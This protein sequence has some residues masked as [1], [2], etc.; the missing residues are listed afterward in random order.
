MINTAKYE[1]Q[2]RI[3]GTYIGD[4]RQLA[5]NLKWVRR[6]TRVGVDEIDFT[7]ND[8]L[9]QK[10]CLERNVDINTMLKPLALDCRIVRNGVPVVGGFLATMP[11]YNP[12]GTSANLD[13]RFDG[14]LN[15]LA[16][17]YMYPVGTQTGR[18]GTLI[19]NWIQL[20][21]QRATDAGKGFN[22]ASG[23][24][25]TMESVIYTF[26]NYKAIKEAITD[27]C[28]NVTGAGP[29]DVFFHPDRTYDIIK[30]SEF[31]DTITDYTI[32]YPTEL[33]A[34]SATQISASEVD[35]FASSVIG[36]GS[37]EISSEADKNTAIT[38]FMT[39]SDAV[40]EFGYAET[41]LQDSSVS[42]QTT[43]DQNSAALLNT[44]SNPI[45]QPQVV[46]IGR[47]VNPTPNGEKKI[48]IGDTVVVNNSEDLT[49]M[50]NGAFRVNELAVDVSATGGETITPVLERVL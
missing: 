29:F 28:D 26:D 6:R 11:S 37:G 38:T 47:Q 12:N 39:N 42:R 17:V 36:I 32:D 20:A 1:V 2:L 50:T 9:F 8:V 48:W 34:T 3:D 22:L 43:L 35:G 24:I 19:D 5:Q 33:N 41:I 45:W 18:M 25:S 49:G 13:L 14:Y 4:V 44:S 23:T 40:A 7:I 15:Y 31:G 10:W 46:L 16:G 30:D 21:N 27:R